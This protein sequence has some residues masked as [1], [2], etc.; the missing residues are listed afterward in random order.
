MVT[1]NA[2]KAG[3]AI[4]WGVGR[5]TSTTGLT[6]YAFSATP[7]NGTLNL[8]YSAP[9]GQWP[10][11]GGNAN[12]VPMVANGLV[13]VGGYKTLMIFGSNGAASNAAQVMAAEDKLVPG[14]RRITGTLLEARGPQLILLTRLSDHIAV[15]AS[16]A[17]AAQRSAKLRVGEAYTIIAPETV[18]GSS[19]RAT[20]I[21][22]AKPGQGAWPTDR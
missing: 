15:D 16:A 19:M 13:Y 14:L 20:S 12:V 8:L 10:N 11:L 2:R 1:S 21:T 4:I 7:T 9:A 22:R 5:P 18:S 17:A 3:S 6:L